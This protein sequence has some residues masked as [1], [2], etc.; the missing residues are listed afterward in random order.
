MPHDGVLLVMVPGAG[1]VAGDFAAQGLVDEATRRC[2]G[3]A[4]RAVDPGIESYLDGSVEQRLLAGIATVRCET[5]AARVWLAGISLGCQGI[6]RGMRRS[7]GL[8]DGIILMTPY[9]GSTGLIAEIAGAGGL[10]SWRPA[11]P[12][13][14]AAVLAWLA[15]ARLPRTILGRVLAD[16]F[17]TTSDLLAALLPPEDV[18]AVAGGH[19]WPGWRAL[20]PRILNREPFA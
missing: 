3:L 6:L 14:E 8:A 1:I 11:S 19:D 7:P 10:R 18:V 4:V 20:W 2:P 16:R 15:G 5:G 17:A 13:P 12:T 9:L